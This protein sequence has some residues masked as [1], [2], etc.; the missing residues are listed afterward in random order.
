MPVE[1]SVR[2]RHDGVAVVHGAVF[3]SE[4]LG[5]VDEPPAKRCEDA[6]VVSH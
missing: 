4:E 6:S 1:D 2:E 5:M 3:R